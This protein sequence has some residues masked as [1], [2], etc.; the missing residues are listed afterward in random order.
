[1]SAQLVGYFKKGIGQFYLQ[2]AECEDQD[3]NYEISLVKNKLHITVTEEQINDNFNSDGFKTIFK[4]NVKA[5]G[6]FV[7]T[8]N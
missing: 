5:F 2:T 4:G 8:H 6:D 7:N 1:L 3:Y